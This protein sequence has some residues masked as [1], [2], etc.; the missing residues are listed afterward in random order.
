[1]KVLIVGAGYMCS[2]YLKVLQDQHIDFQV[3]GRSKGGVQ[4][5]QEK[6]PGITCFD[7]GVDS[8]LEC[9][10]PPEH[11][12][13]T[14]NVENLFS[15]TTAL[16]KSGVKNILLEKPGA[17]NLKDLSELNQL[18]EKTETKVWI[19]YNRRFHLSTDIASKMIEEDQGILS[20]HFEFTEWVHT[21]DPERFDKETLNHWVLANSSHVIDLV[22]F[23]CGRPK[24]IYPVVAGS[25]ISW[26]PAGSIFVGAGQTENSIPFSYHANWGA[27]GRW[28]VE[29]LTAK[30]RLFFQPMERLKVQN[31]GSVTLSDVEADYS[32]DINF[33]PGLFHQTMAFLN[34]ADNFKA[35]PLAEHLLNCTYFWKIAG[36]QF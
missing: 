31:L 16:L 20:C 11:A 12:I 17:L 34:E 19:A 8:F 36:Y 7:G 9:N 5:L 21:I 6:F 13:V 27:P 26:H 24:E 32:T 33:K 30:R 1:M 22:F 14:T 23:F 28:S 3:V 4:R 18:A 35:C 29:L 2:E 10:H 15:A 25:S